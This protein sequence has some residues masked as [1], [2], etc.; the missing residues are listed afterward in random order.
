MSYTPPEKNSI[1]FVLSSYSAPIRTAI[2][3]DFTVVLPGIPGIDG[4][5]VFSEDIPANDEGDFNFIPDL[6]VIT[7]EMDFELPSINIDLSGGLRVNRLNI[8][9]PSLELEIAGTAWKGAEGFI[10]GDLNITLPITECVFYKE[11]SSLNIELPI[12]ELEIYTRVPEITANLDCIIPISFIEFSQIDAVSSIITAEVPFFKV[13]LTGDN[14]YTVLDLEIPLFDIIS[15][16]GSIINLAFP[17]LLFDG[18][19]R[20]NLLGAL[21]LEF[22]IV[23]FQGFTSGKGILL[24]VPVITM[25][26]AA[27]NHIVGSLVV[28][29]QINKIEMFTAGEGI[30]IDLPI[31]QEIASAD[32]H[33]VG[34]LD[35]GLPTKKAEMI[36]AGEGLEIA[37]PV[38]DAEIAADNHILGSLVSALPKS[39]MEMFTSGEGFKTSL[40]TIIFESA[41]DNH[42]IGSL[43]FNLPT[44]VAEIFIFT[45]DLLATIPILTLTANVDNHII[46]SIKTSFPVIDLE[47]IT[48]G[49]GVSTTLPIFDLA[50]TGSTPI[51]TELV[52]SLPELTLS[53]S[54]F[55]NITASIEFDLPIVSSTISSGG[56]LSFVLPNVTCTITGD[57]VISGEFD[58]SVPNKSF[59]MYASQAMPTD[60]TFVLPNVVFTGNASDSLYNT[61][62]TALPLLYSK[63][64]AINNGLSDL[65]FS[66]PMM[67]SILK[68]TWHREG[69]NYIALDLPEMVMLGQY[70]NSTTTGILRHVRGEVR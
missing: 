1:N 60:L 37:I 56:Y 5:F 59:E 16:S 31:I 33:I 58:L 53:I 25:A 2:S 55:I 4:N 6:A 10:Y 44:S 35:F 3:F 13:T 23:V 49:P 62:D 14:N 27:D 46:G 30:I 7:S 11:G 50:L 22:P 66:V 9:L 21:D 61:I 34:S 39:V 26:M 43:N 70:T 42:I 15:F 41:A 51:S 40:P 68:A 32:N 24:D 8:N 64:H 67:K 38:L 47:M 17:E 29:L 48:S 57:A 19:I 65:E 63:L 28:P 20:T 54:A 69:G 18:L 45:K 12:Q 52:V 36:T